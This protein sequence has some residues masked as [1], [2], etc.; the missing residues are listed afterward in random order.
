[1]SRRLFLVLPLLAYSVCFTAISAEAP[2]AYTQTS[3]SVPANG[4]PDMLSR[5]VPG[6][7]VIAVGEGKREAQYPGDTL[8]KAGKLIERLQ[9]V[10]EA[11]STEDDTLIPYRVRDTWIIA[12]ESREEVDFDAAFS[13]LDAASRSTICEIWLASLTL[14]ELERLGSRQGMPV[15]QFSA[16]GQDLIA[17]LLR[18][19]LDIHLDS[20]LNVAGSINEP[21]DL[22]KVR[23]RAGLVISTAHVDTG[24]TVMADIGGGPI[25]P[26]RTIIPKS[27]GAEAYQGSMPYVVTV[28]NTFKPSDLDGKGHP[29]PFGASGVMTVVDALKRVESVTGLH[30]AADLPFKKQLVYVGA[31]TAT[32]GDILD[33]LRLGLTAAFRRLG[34]T[35]I[36]AWDRR[37]L[38][39]VQRLAAE[40]RYI[41]A[42]GVA[43]VQNEAELS[44]I[45]LRMGREMPFTEDSPFSLTDEQRAILLQP[46][47]WAANKLPKIPFAQMTPEQQQTVRAMGQKAFYRYPAPSY[48]RESRPATEEEVQ[49]AYFTLEARTEISV[50]IPGYGWLRLLAG[51][52]GVDTYRVERIR[53]HIAGRP[54][55]DIT[56]PDSYVEGVK[57]AKPRSIPASFRGI[58]LPLLT[59][60]RA[61]DAIRSAKRKGFSAV[62]YPA[63]YDGYASFPT[64]SFPVHPA[65]KGKDGWALAQAAAKAAGI[66]LIGTVDVLSW[67]RWGDKTHWL[68]KHPEWIDLDVA[69]R[70]RVAWLDTHPEADPFDFS[71]SVAD[72]VRPS[73]PSVES[74]LKQLLA[75][76]AKRGGIEGIAIADWLPGA[77]E[78]QTEYLVTR[79]GPPALG[80]SIADRL[81]SFRKLGRDPVD[82]PKL[83]DFRSPLFVP[84]SL[85]R[86]ETGAGG[87]ESN[88]PWTDLTSRLL[89]SA[90]QANK[91]WSV[92]LFAGGSVIP[93]PRTR[94]NAP[95]DEPPFAPT[96]VDEPI[97]TILNIR[98][99]SAKTTD[100]QKAMLGDRP[101][102]VWGIRGWDS[103]DKRAAG[104]KAT[105]EPSIIVDLRAAP[106]DVTESL[107]WIIAP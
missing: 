77:G 74:R 26:G 54:P 18:P 40:K 102:I 61:A 1:M 10:S 79:M 93:D 48:M 15:G 91:K 78:V 21:P 105:L 59:P 29:Q 98:P 8:K 70:T 19:P 99:R 73:E 25:P 64:D 42:K 44:A 66:S 32:C 28:E 30:L 12:P 50:E 104:G 7:R 86:F 9:A 53:R 33:A 72:C 101:Y 49:K 95:P 22:S 60:E 5:A 58:A 97:G 34:N 27:S 65:L 83:Y 20:P 80:Y 103:A 47:D 51:G 17:R 87:E 41:A 84:R 4:L 82:V 38:A 90:R 106:D 57:A 52:G 81:A 46:S 14:S 107:S 43:Q 16:A 100:S 11:Q 75:D 89:D 13:P 67:R 68:T 3:I 71:V 39:A 76:F 2:V 56:A 37:G 96:R 36:L 88:R 55:L 94:L 69:A 23:I 63:L 62:F 45:W 6:Q 85:A 24:D 31:P 92:Y 35:Y